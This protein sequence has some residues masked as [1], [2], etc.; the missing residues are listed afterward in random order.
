MA[1]GKRPYFAGTL[2]GRGLLIVI[3]V[4][5]YTNDT[6]SYAILRRRGAAVTVRGMLTVSMIDQS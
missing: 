5:M 2:P 6:R 3:W 4:N 1:K